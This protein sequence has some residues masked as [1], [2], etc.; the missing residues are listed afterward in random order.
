MLY[1][2]HDETVGHEA[3]EALEVEGWGQIRG[4]SVGNEWFVV[5]G[6]FVIERADFDGEGVVWVG[7]AFADGSLSDGGYELGGCVGYA[8]KDGVGDHGR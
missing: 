2:G 4:G 1:G 5:E 8:T 6:V 3:D 7:T